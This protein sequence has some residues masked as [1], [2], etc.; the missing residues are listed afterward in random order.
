MILVYCCFPEK[1]NET[2]T[3]FFVLKFPLYPC[4]HAGDYSDKEGEQ[5]RSIYCLL[6]RPGQKTCLLRLPTL[7]VL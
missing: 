7:G 6:D 2:L 1:K 4:S 5:L 3:F